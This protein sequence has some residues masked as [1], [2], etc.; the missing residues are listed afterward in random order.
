VVLWIEG[1]AMPRLVGSARTEGGEF[2]WTV[3][4]AGLPMEVVAEL[5]PATTFDLTTAWLDEG[6]GTWEE[7]YFTSFAVAD[8][9]R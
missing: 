1:E 8:L 4:A 5:A 6:S 9:T 2:T 3:D 7:F